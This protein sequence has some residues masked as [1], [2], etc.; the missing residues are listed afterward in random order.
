MQAALTPSRQAKALAAEPQT[1]PRSGLLQGARETLS[2][3]SITPE[4]WS[5]PPRV[6]LRNLVAYTRSRPRS[7]RL[8]DEVRFGRVRSVHSVH[9]RRTGKRRIEEQHQTVAHEAGQCSFV[10]HDDRAEGLIVFAEQPNYFVRFDSGRKAGEPAKVAE[11]DGDVRAAAVEK[12]FPAHALN[13]FCDLGREE[14]LE[15]GNTL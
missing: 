7:L 5:P 6:N 1:R 10:P 13:E 12:P 4:P 2:A 14:A 8:P 9:S 15:P 11:N 3:S